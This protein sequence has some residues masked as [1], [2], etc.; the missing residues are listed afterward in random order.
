MMQRARIWL[1]V[2][3]LTAPMVA[4]IF[5]PD[6]VGPWI[7]VAFAYP[8]DIVWLSVYDAISLLP[9]FVNGTFRQNRLWIRVILYGVVDAVATLVYAFMPTPNTWGMALI[10]P[11]IILI[12]EN[13]RII[14]ARRRPVKHKD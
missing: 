12:P 13:L 2:L 11:A 8:K 6:E 7:K 5:C 4:L 14:S 9:L 10:L 3:T 1:V